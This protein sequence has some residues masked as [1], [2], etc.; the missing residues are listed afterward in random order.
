MDLTIVAVYMICDDLLI[1]LGHQE[2][3]QTQMTDAEVMT[4]TLVAVRY[5]AGN[6]QRRATT[7][8]KCNKI[9]HN[10]KHLIYQTPLTLAIRW[11]QK[12]IERCNVR[13]C[14]SVDSVTCLGSIKT[15]SVDASIC[16]PME[17]IKV[18][19]VAVIWSIAFEGML[20]SVGRIVPMRR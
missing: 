16:S 6:H 9:N 2:H 1:S 4:T 8:M 15:T 7:P 10:I 17:T 11:N 13:G 5:F 18:V 12:P 14:P 19:F 20:S 3:S